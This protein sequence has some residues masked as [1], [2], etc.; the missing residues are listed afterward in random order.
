MLLKRLALSSFT[1]LPSLL[2]F[3]SAVRL[4]RL[5]RVLMGDPFRDAANFNSI[6]I[7]DSFLQ[8]RGCPGGQFGDLSF[9]LNSRGFRTAE[10]GASKLPGVQGIAI[11]GDSC[12]FGVVATSVLALK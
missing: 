7:P 2:V 5:D 4:L 8:W 1:V 9:R 11:L 12:T 10:V 6:L 3:E